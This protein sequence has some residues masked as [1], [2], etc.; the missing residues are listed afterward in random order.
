MNRF[1]VL[2]FF[3]LSACVHQEKNKQRSDD[4]HKIAIG[5]L[6]QCDRERALSHLIKAVKYDPKNFIL[7]HSL[8]ATYYSMEDY[9]RSLA[10]YQKS[11]E[12]EPKLTE[13]RVS[14]VGLLIRV[15]Q[16]NR[17]EKELIKAKKDK[18]YPDTLKLLVHQSWLDYEKGRYANAKRGFE[19]ALS[20]KKG[21]TCFNHL[22]LGQTEKALG[23]LEPALE[24]LKQALFK[25]REM[26]KMP[27]YKHHYEEYFEIAEVY[28]KKQDKKK[29]IYYLKLF[30]EK[31]GKEVE[32]AKE[33]LKKISALSE[34]SSKGRFLN[35]RLQ[36]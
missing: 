15:N 19:E 7:R 27:C 14:M 20:L 22:K 6:K 25:C 29:A 36:V 2:V 10:E 4:H 35:Y 9:K 23:N 3:V 24:Q 16:L 28:L 34:P 5:L 21:K 11:L 1:F 31:S 13:S 26:D 18:T 30:I 8:A 33:L 32:K 17:A 12:L